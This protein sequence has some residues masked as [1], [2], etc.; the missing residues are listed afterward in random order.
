MISSQGL[1][2]DGSAVGRRT[3]CCECVSW[4]VSFSATRRQL[5]G[6]FAAAFPLPRLELRSQVRAWDDARRR[7]IGHGIESE[8][9][10]HR[11]YKLAQTFVEKL[12]TEIRDAGAE[13]FD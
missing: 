8:I 6:R 4:A 5:L 2:E 10:C 13:A 7:E 12:G 3:R 11:P 1:P 9:A